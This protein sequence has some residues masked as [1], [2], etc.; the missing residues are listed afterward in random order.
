MTA[1]TIGSAE[2]AEA[3]GAR[4]EWIRQQCHDG[5][6]PHHLIAGRLRFTPD[7]VEAILQL[8]ARPVAAAATPARPAV[9]RYASYPAPVEA[10]R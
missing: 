4:P 6:F 8:T 10:T 7:D 3:L 9:R 5:R 2:L 1:T